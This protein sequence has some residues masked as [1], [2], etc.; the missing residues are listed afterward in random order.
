MLR[1]LL[2]RFFYGACAL[3]A[4][5]SCGDT[6]A[7]GT[8]EFATVYATANPPAAEI[9]ADVTTWV[10]GTG[11]K[12]TA[13]AAGSLITVLPDNAV[14]T[15]TSAAYPAANTG[16]TSTIP[17]SNL[18]ITKISFTLTP[19][20]SLSPALPPL[21]QSQQSSPGQIITPGS[22]SVTVQI[23]T[24]DIK[25]YLRT[26]TTGALDCSG[27]GVIYSYWAVASFQAL[28][29]NTNR[30]ATLTAPALLVKFSDFIDK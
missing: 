27:Q 26:L 25:N 7:G 6:K 23:A 10:D 14:Y 30:V 4:L 16:T 19:A 12:A 13:C 21:F 3:V 22:N 11:A 28:E 17:T 24:D 9:D 15:V 18:S 20:N 29:V 2:V 8:G 5:S 1:S